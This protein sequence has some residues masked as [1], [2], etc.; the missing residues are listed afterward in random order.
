MWLLLPKFKHQLRFRDT[1]ILTLLQP[2]HVRW[3]TSGLTVQLRV[4]PR[5]ILSPASSLLCGLVNSFPSLAMEPPRT[6]KHSHQDPEP[7]AGAWLSGQAVVVPHLPCMDGAW[8]AQSDVEQRRVQERLRH[9]KVDDLHMIR[10]PGMCM[11]VGS[12]SNQTNWSVISSAFMSPM[13][14]L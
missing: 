8:A 14:V 10:R 4:T 3:C 7:Q 6:A 2:P 11:R 5:C 13:G 1:A 9:R 12:P